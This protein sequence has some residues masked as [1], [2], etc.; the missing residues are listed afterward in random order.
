MMKVLKSLVVVLAA[1]VCIAM[2]ASAAAAEGNDVNR[3]TKITF[4]QPVEVPGHVLPAGTYTFKLVTFQGVRNIVRIYNEDG[5]KVITTLLAIYDTRLKPTE[6]PVIEFR[7]QKS[8][9]PAAIKA[10]FY[11]FDTAG[12]EFVYPK[13]RA[14]ELATAENA[15]VPAAEVE[16]TPANLETVPLVAEMP[17]NTE[18]PITEAFPTTPTQPM[19]A[20]E[21]QPAE[22]LPKTASPVPLIGLIGLVSISLGGAL[23]LAFAV[24]RS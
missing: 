23:R 13:A 15:P 6:K 2:L 3:S 24:R 11:A 9:S 22:A 1:F 19:V 20:E 7:E 18:E 14:A 5:T 12:L 10:W 21:M 4:N 8:T 16:E 17:G